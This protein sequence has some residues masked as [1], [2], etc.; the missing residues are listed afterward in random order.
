[1]TNRLFLDLHVLQTMPPSN[2]N[3]DDSGSPKDAVYGGV[4]RARVSS[5]SWKRAT[6]RHLLAEVRPE[7]RSM[8]TERLQD[9]IAEKLCLGH[10]GDEEHAATAAVLARGAVATLTDKWKASNRTRT[11]YTFFLQRSG[12]EEIAAK[13]APR[14]PE[15]AETA[16]DARTASERELL[17]AKRKKLKNEKKDPKAVA[18]AT[19]TA[20][21]LAKAADAATAAL[22]EALAP[23][24][25]WDFLVGRPYPPE[26]ALFGRM[27][28]DRTEFNVD[29]SVQVAHAL[30][31]HDTK[32]EFDYFTTVDDFRTGG[33]G[34]V[35]D[36]GPSKGGPA[37]MLGT[38][39]FNAATY[40]RFATIAVHQLFDNLGAAEASVDPT[41]KV[42]KDFIR[43]FA[44]S[45]PSGHQ[46]TFGHSTR[47]HLLVVSA[48]SDAPVNLV[49]AFERPIWETD[50]RAAASMVRLAEE[51]D[52]VEANWGSP[53]GKV[54]AT[55]IERGD[56]ARG[57]LAE[58]FGASV[59]L[60]D[61]LDQI[62]A[63]TAATLRGA[64]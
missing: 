50:G 6:R 15:L 63:Y 23:D 46:N 4:R 56:K 31:T 17:E 38:V 25:L 52:D 54:L 40:Y 30:S 47:P 41:A 16:R 64:P 62:E 28:A 43:S 58:S 55:Y 22:A 49:T 36:S 11:A 32:V 42:A 48:R 21:E 61:L 51:H 26:I 1:M 35:L 60:P 24:G 27:V 19:L 12:V 10:E 13:L 34:D 39:E 37:T 20:A 44:L 45:I 53:A 29:G 18:D 2:L 9:A 59:P 8:R 57:R 14:W 33:N 5:Q 3:R 7:D